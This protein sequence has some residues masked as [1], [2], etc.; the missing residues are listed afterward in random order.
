[1]LKR[2]QAGGAL[3]EGAVD[4]AEEGEGAALLAEAVYEAARRGA[5]A[6]HGGE[7]PVALGAG[8]QGLRDALGGGE[9]ARDGAARHAA[10]HA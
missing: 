7:G 9:D 6:E 3:D 2:K 5:R 1:M 8:E 10:A 4:S